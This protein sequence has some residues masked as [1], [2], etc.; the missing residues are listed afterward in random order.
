MH[1]KGSF[2]DPRFK[3]LSYEEFKDCS[4]EL[5]ILT[6]AVKLEYK[7]TADLKAKLKLEFMELFY[8]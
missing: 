4:V 6:P 1:K 3:P 2:E 7:D 8:N 5:S